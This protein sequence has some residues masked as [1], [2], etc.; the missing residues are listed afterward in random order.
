MEFEGV[1][2]MA[3]VLDTC[4]GVSIA[5]VS[6]DALA[7]VVR[8]P[9]PAATAERAIA[10]W[11]T[12]TN[13]HIAAVMGMAG[14]APDNEAVRLAAAGRCRAA[15]VMPP[16]WDP[17]LYRVRINGAGAMAAFM[18]SQM[19]LS[20][21]GIARPDGEAG[22]LRKLDGDTVLDVFDP[23]AATAVRRALFETYLLLTGGDFDFD[24]R[25][26]ELGI[27]CHEYPEAA[28]LAK[29]GGATRHR[30]EQ[31][32]KNNLARKII[33]MGGTSW[34]LDT[35]TVIKPIMER[36]GRMLGLKSEGGSDA[37]ACKYYQFEGI[38]DGPYIFSV[39]RLNAG[40][41][42]YAGD[43]LWRY[44]PRFHGDPKPPRQASFKYHT[45]CYVMLCYV[46]P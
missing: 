1:P 32:T 31:L 37:D 34:S 3:A 30:M 2:D 28:A 43:K 17:A 9:V 13:F 11:A 25:C 35:D 41:P 16:G 33:G 10:S 18:V 5:M 8:V 12:A 45:L 15:N 46:M 14:W 19:T 7:I 27:S 36:N 40:V 26:A 23:R 4:P 44:I 42:V 22:C 38:R 21:L 20:E 6:H 29:T 39:R 24:K